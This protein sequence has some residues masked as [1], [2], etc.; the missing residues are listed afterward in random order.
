MRTPMETSSPTVIVTLKHNLLLQH[1]MPT[2]LQRGHGLKLGH[3][4]HTLLQKEHDPTPSLPVRLYRLVPQFWS[5]QQNGARMIKIKLDQIKKF[6]SYQTTRLLVH[7]NY[8]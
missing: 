2:L 1:L 7:L 6:G 4:S 5:L 8:V 3:L